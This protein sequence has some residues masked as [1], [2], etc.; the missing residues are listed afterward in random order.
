MHGVFEGSEPVCWVSLK[1]NRLEYSRTIPHLSFPPLGR[2]RRRPWSRTLMPWGKG[3]GMRG[4]RGG[5]GSLGTGPGMGVQEALAPG[6]ARRIRVDEIAPGARRLVRGRVKGGEQKE[7]GDAMD[8]STMGR[9]KHDRERPPQ[10]NKTPTL[11]TQRHTSPGGSSKS[12]ENWL[13]LTGMWRTHTHLSTAVECGKYSPNKRRGYRWGS[14]PPGT[15]SNR[16]C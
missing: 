14:N 11:P 5:G 7:A 10:V 15:V 16:L 9:R 4:M 2:G 13:P 12:K 3:G 1:K 8:Q 6:G